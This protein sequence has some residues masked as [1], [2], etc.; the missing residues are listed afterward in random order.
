MTVVLASGSAA[1][2]HMLENAGIEIVVD[3]A[4]V[5]EE[6]VKDA[7]RADGA[8][9]QDVAETLAELKATTVSR[10]HPSAL[11]LGADQMLDCDGRWLNKPESP[12][13]AAETLRTLRGR[14][15]ELISAA[16]LVRDGTRIWHAIDRVSL[17]M[18]HL[19]EDFIDSYL[20]HMGKDA[21]Q[22]VGAYQLE[23]LGAQLFTRVQGDFFTVLGLPLLPLLAQLR[24]LGE[25]PE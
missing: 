22:S 9:V 18:R 8:P 24:R 17:E 23:G 5:D 19:S 3:P 2:R 14:T 15:H 21:M 25:I 16:V 4:S 12:D 6:T 20:H 10:R 11:V 7:L 1:R 13:D